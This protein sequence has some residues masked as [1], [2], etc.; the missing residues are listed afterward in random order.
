[1]EL[2]KLGKQAAKHDP[3]TLKLADYVTL[4][5]YPMEYEWSKPVTKLGMMRN[6]QLSCCVPAG[7]GHSLQTCSANAG[8]EIIVSD[9]DIVKEY[10]NFS[11]YNPVTGE[12]DNGCIM[13][14]SLKHVYNNGFAGNTIKAFVSV[15]LANLELIKF[16]LYA[17]GGILEGIALPESSQGADS[18]VMPLPGQNGQRGSW[19]GHCVYGP[20]MFP[21]F[22][23]VDSWGTEM[24]MEWPFLTTYADEAYVVIWNDFIVNNESPVKIDMV[25]LLADLKIVTA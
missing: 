21:D 9:D 20:D 8:N 19:G 11:G 17:F 5:P 18:F 6:D 23:R 15:N 25:Q 12:N 16:A 7:I 10:T 1:M 13:L 24:R 4:P 14:D 22:H 2:F 3:R